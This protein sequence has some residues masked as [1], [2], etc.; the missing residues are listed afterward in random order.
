V[1]GLPSQSTPA[2]AAP[3]FVCELKVDGAVV[4]TDAGVKGALCSMRPW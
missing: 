3:G 1:V 2:L 4:A